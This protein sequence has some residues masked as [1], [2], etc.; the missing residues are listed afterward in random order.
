[1]RRA[2]ELP[3]RTI[4]VEAAQ[5]VIS[6]GPYALVRHPMYSAMTVMIIF[7]ALALGSV[8]ALLPA[9][10]FVLLLVARIR[11]EEQVLRRELAGYGDYCQTVKYRLVPGVW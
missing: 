11:N 9:A 5:P 6:T 3:F 2:H 7:S 10:L 1:M 8:W 4:E